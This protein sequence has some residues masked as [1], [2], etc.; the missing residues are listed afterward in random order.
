MRFD[1]RER[2]ASGVAIPIVGAL[3]WRDRYV[4]QL[5]L[6]VAVGLLAAPSA[7]GQTRTYRSI[8]WEKL[9]ASG[10]ELKQIGWLAVRHAK[11]VESSPWSVGCETLDRD[12]A[13]FSVYKDYVGELGVKHARVSMNT[14]GQAYRSFSGWGFYDRKRIR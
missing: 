12:Q 2:S 4:R 11:D 9:K 3:P 8:T 6:T 5:V 13:K 7:F 1:G 10:P 14:Q